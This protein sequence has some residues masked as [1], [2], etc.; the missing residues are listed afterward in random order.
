MTG[1]QQVQVRL[2]PEV[3]E[4]LDAYATRLR[5]ETALNVTRSDAIRKL[6]VIGLAAVEAEEAGNKSRRRKKE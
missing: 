5:L 2:D 1:K 6:I 4:K 3:I